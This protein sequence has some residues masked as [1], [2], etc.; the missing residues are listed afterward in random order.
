[1]FRKA[2]IILKNNLLFFSEEE[3]QILRRTDEGDF[4][5]PKVSENNF[6]L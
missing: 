5:L 2:K 6:V 3:Y 4:P 1:M